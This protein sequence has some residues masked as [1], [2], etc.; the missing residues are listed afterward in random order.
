M[1]ADRSSRFNNPLRRPFRLFDTVEQEL[2]ATTKFWRNRTPQERLEYLEFMRCIDF[3][4]EEVNAPIVRCYDKR[5]WTETEP[6]GD[7]IVY[8]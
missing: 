6:A 2:A 3:G 8:F 7:T 1:K 5:K 4:E